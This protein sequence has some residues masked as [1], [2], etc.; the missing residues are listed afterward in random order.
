MD[1]I[2]NE[3]VVLGMI[4]TD[5]S[6]IFQYSIDT[7]DF[8]NSAHKILFGSINELIKLNIQI[9]I[10]ALTSF[11]IEKALY[12]KLE[13][14]IG[15]SPVEY[16]TEIATS[17]FSVANFKFHYDILKNNRK[18]KELENLGQDLIKSLNNNEVKTNDLI[19]STQKRLLEINLNVQ[20]HYYNLEDIDHEHYEELQNKLNNKNNH[21]GMD[22]GFEKINQVIGGF[23]KSQVIILAARPGIGK[24][25]LAL[26]LAVSAA[27]TNKENI[28][29]FSLEMSQQELY[30]RILSFSSHIEM[31]KYKYGKLNEEDLQK[32][33]ITR[34]RLKK[35]NIYINDSA[36]MKVNDIKNDVYRLEREKDKV[37]LV[38]VDYLQLLEGE[39]AES[40]Y[41]QVS[42]ISRELKQL[43]KDLNV[44]VLVLSQLNREVETRKGK[45]PQLSDLRDSGAIE[46]DAD[47]VGL[48]HV[49]QIEYNDDV[50]ILLLDIA[51]N[52][53]GRTGE[54][55][56]Y[57]HK[58]TNQFY[59]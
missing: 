19:E 7:K 56:L 22:T 27:Q 29:L 41:A 49:D 48:M 36:V 47:I 37:G 18:L 40:R 35:L 53:H 45:R 42:Q 31:Y 25:S 1:R 15:F 20:H 51:K 6:L 55:P 43:A 23:V 33:N 10:M 24:T 57:F 58:P 54:I 11:L 26:N 30:N 4:I 16:L 32:D 46:Q 9:D 3:Q 5:P 12:D 2:Q 34:D 59:E 39:R 52:R 8:E 38:I 44:C 17:I 21:T 13:S 28:M 50:D 14:L